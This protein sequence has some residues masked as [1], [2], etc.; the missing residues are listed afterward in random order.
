MG[1]GYTLSDKD[2]DALTNRITDLEAALRDSTDFLQRV[3]SL[4]LTTSDPLHVRQDR[5]AG[6][7]RRIDAN[8]ALGTE[9]PK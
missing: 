8:R 5:V 2:M 3:Q 4:L 7:Q 1:S 6:V 9:T